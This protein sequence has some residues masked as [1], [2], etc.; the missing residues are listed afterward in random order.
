M[1]R[2]VNFS[3]DNFHDQNNP[4]NFYFKKK[5]V[6]S[7]NWNSRLQKSY[8][9]S[10]YV[11]SFVKNIGIKVA[12]ALNFLSNSNKKKRSSPKVS[13][14][15]TTTTTSLTR[16]S[17][18]AQTLIYDSQRAQAIEDCIEFL[19]SSSSSSSLHRSSS[20]SSTTCY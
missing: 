19:N 13:S 1:S 18:Y 7:S 8:S 20:V 16:S 15:S 10:S 17:S 9:S 11:A 14:S 5:P 12:S 3:P 6:S 4:T 2:R